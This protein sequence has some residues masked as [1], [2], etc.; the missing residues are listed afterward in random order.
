MAKNH[1]ARRLMAAAVAAAALPGLA[2]AVGCVA[3]A[4]AAQPEFLHVPSPS[5]G[6]D[7]TV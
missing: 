6:H 2:G 1:W 5:M 4:R 3:P 7:I